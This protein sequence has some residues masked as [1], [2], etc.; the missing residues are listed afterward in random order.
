MAVIELAEFDDTPPGYCP[1]C[2]R[3]LYVDSDKLATVIERK[4]NNC[5]KLA[6]ARYDRSRRG[7]T[8]RVP[9]RKQTVAAKRGERFLPWG[10]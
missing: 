6:E 7:H 5:H 4:H 1:C 10:Y 3:L 9:Y 2:C 8:E